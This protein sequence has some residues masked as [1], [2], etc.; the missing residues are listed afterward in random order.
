MGWL[1]F[2]SQPCLAHYPGIAGKPFFPR[3]SLLPFSRG[4]V[5]GLHADY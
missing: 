3:H 1:Y 5:S 4:H 2:Y